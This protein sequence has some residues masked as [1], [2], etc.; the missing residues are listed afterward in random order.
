M[1]VSTHQILQ[2]LGRAVESTWTLA[3]RGGTTD[4]AVVG[5]SGCPC[6]Y[7]LLLCSILDEYWVSFVSMEGIMAQAFL[8]NLIG[9]YLQL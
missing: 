2:Q 6:G 3:L 1:G 8:G 7:A 9:K 4:T 5:G